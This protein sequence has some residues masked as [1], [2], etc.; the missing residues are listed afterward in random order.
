M[1]NFGT[2]QGLKIPNMSF[3]TFQDP[4]NHASDNRGVTAILPMSLHYSL[5]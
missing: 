4:G 2:F 3:S 1:S 5:D